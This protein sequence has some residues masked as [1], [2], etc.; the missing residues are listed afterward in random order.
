MKRCNIARYLLIFLWRLAFKRLRRLCFAIFFSRHF[1]SD[2]IVRLL[3]VILFGRAVIYTARGGFASALRN[4]LVEADFDDAL[5]ARRFQLGLDFANDLLV[6]N[7]LD[8]HP[9]LVA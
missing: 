9:A 1:F 7:R 6:D 3:W 8:R 5:R 2:P 4:N